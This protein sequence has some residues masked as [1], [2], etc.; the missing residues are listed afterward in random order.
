[1]ITIEQLRAICPQA[2][3]AKL[4][5]IVDPLNDA[6][7]EFEIDA[8]PDR[9]AAFL[10]Q[11]AHESGQFNYLRE[12]WGPT[13]AQAGYEGR[14]DLGNYQPG[15]GFKFRGRGLIQC[16]GRL[17]YKKC[18]EALGL[19]LEHF[20]EML[21]ALVPACRSAGWFWQTHGLNEL[22][23]AADFERITRRI[24]GGLNG[25]AERC[26]FLQRAEGALA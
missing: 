20:P 10:A 5:A 25:Y 4:A 1:M 3:D 17:N 11:V 19:D 6:M 7:R 13:P 15:D 26:A 24:N 23:D 21:E 9:A 12:I 22:A 18:G 14:V 16:T 8:L 2:K